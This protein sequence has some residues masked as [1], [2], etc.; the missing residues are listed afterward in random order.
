MWDAKSYQIVEKN[1]RRPIWDAKLTKSWQFVEKNSPEAKMRRQKID[2][3]SKK[4]A[5]GQNVTP[6]LQK[7]K[8][9]Q[10]K[11]NLS[12]SLITAFHADSEFRSPNPPFFFW[13]KNAGFL[14]CPSGFW[15]SSWTI[16]QSNN[17]SNNQTT[18]D[19]QS[20]NQSKAS[21]CQLRWFGFCLC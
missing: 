10:W 6:K 17:Q 7:K 18:T 12:I 15:I 3:S 1:S 9:N 14:W 19:S 20:N 8:K 11:T 5:G 4:T 21:V 2:N 16:K 13:W